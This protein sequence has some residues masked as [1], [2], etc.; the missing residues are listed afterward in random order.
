MV[1]TKCLLDK[2]ETEFNRRSRTDPRPRTQCKICNRGVRV[3][4]IRQP[5]AESKQ[6]WLDNNRPQRNA[7]ERQYNQRPEVK[8]RRNRSLAKTGSAREQVN[9]RRVR[10]AKA[11]GSHTKAEWLDLC[12]WVGNKCVVPGCSRTDLTRDHIVPLSRGGTDYI[13]NIQPLCRSHNSK[14]GTKMT[15]YRRST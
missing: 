8:T 1:C 5:S 15:N 6:R 7:W 12:A 3:A 10:L 13:N 2:P 9:R 14:K 4:P 11:Q